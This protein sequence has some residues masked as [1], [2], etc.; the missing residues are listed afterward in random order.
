MYNNTIIQ[1]MKQRKSIHFFYKR[2]E[3]FVSP[4]VLGNKNGKVHLLGYQYFGTS[5]QGRILGESRKNFRCF[6]IESITQLNILDENLHLP[7]NFHSKKEN[8]CVEH[9]I[10]QINY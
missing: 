4:Y 6:K 7:R 8:S 10:F 5:S 3:R 9:V 2:H 1:A